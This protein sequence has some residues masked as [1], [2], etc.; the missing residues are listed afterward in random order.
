LNNCGYIVC[1]TTLKALVKKAKDLISP[2][3]TD[4]KG[5]LL[6]ADDIRLALSLLLSSESYRVIEAYPPKDVIIK[7]SQ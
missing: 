2:N 5:T 7:A 1:F 6:V 4:F 3:V